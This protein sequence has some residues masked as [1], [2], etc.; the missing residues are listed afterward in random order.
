M[1]GCK[2]CVA[3]RASHARCPATAEAPTAALRGDQPGR[4]IA[5]EHRKPEDV[6]RYD[7]ESEFESGSGSSL[8]LSLSLNLSLSL[9]SSLSSRLCLSLRLSLSLNLSLSLRL[10]LSLRKAPETPSKNIISTKQKHHFHKVPKSKLELVLERRGDW[11][12]AP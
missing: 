5:K 7:S 6:S 1:Q 2:R 11:R 4:N 10:G 12:Y 9:S 3:C 8:R